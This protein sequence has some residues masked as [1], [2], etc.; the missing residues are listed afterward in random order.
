MSIAETT[1]VRD[2]LPLTML[3]LSIV[4]IIAIGEQVHIPPAARL[5]P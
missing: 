1:T 4:A 5:P 2:E 3:T